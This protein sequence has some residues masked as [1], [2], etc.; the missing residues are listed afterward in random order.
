MSIRIPPLSLKFPPEQ[1][2]P[3]PKPFEAHLQATTGLKLEF[4][5]ARIDQATFEQ[6]AAS[7]PLELNWALGEDGYFD[8]IAI[9]HPAFASSIRLSLTPVY[10]SARLDVPFFRDYL[11]WMTLKTLVDLGAYD[12]KQA[13]DLP[14][15][16]RFTWQ[17]EQLPAAIKYLRELHEEKFNLI[18]KLN[19]NPAYQQLSEEALTRRMEEEEA[20][21]EEAFY[22]KYGRP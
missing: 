21:V 18:A 10:Q 12:P 15:W 22:A 20:A 6:A 2:V 17:D 11:W 16:T 14:D 1:P 8:R 4:A 13:I 3:D 9:A 5:I 7:S 19:E